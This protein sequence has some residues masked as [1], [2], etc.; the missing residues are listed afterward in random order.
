MI[1]PQAA[2]DRPTVALPRTLAE[3]P[4]RAIAIFRA[5][6]IVLL[7]CH[8]VGYFSTYHLELMS[9]GVH[10]Y[11]S[12]DYQSLCLSSDGHRN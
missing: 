12:C 9:T 5:T 8:H 6:R 4:F 2:D 3:D 1:N 10:N 11:I 7:S